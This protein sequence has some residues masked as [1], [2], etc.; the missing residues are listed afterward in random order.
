ML[1]LNNTRP[2]LQV[3]GEMKVILKKHQETTVFEDEDTALCIAVRRRHIWKDAKLVL[4]RGNNIYSR[5]IRV[6]F[7]SETAVDDGGL[8]ESF[9]PSFGWYYAK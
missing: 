4:S 7:V 6:T 9:S 3:E 1:S 8:H 5:G 2:E